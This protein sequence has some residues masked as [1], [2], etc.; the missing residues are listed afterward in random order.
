MDDFTKR[1][2]QGCD[3]L[4]N[5]FNPIN[6]LPPNSVF[7]IRAFIADRKKSWD[8]NNWYTS[9]TDD[10]IVIEKMWLAGCDGQPVYRKKSSLGGYFDE[11]AVKNVL[12]GKEYLISTLWTVPKTSFKP[13]PIPEVAK[14]AK[15]DDVR[16][17]KEAYDALIK[18]GYIPDPKEY[19]GRKKKGGMEFEDFLEDYL[20]QLGKERH[21]KNAARDE[22]KRSLGHFPTDEEWEEF[23]DDYDRRNAKRHQ[24]RGS[25]M[26]D[27]ID[28]VEDDFFDGDDVIPF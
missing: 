1:F 7:S 6:D 4:M 16:I 23:D 17:A 26:E 12:N 13:F 22:F 14:K 18:M 19:G 20:D 15:P 28:E 8:G 11:L 25:I 21:D 5:E 27:F 2:M 24:G 10:E 9:R 3:E